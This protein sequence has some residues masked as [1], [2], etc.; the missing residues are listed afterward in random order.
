VH[1]VTD[2]IVDKMGKV[3]GVLCGFPDDD[4]WEA[5]HRGAADAIRAA[6]DVACFSD[7]CKKHRRGNF[8]AL[9]VG[10]SFGGGQKVSTP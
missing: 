7:E 1:R 3:I 2:H 6:R 4:S 8:P 5:T 10:V 9:A